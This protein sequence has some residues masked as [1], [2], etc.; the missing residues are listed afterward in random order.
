V[1]P[2]RRALGA[3]SN[4]GV[5]SE[6]VRGLRVIN[7]VSGLRGFVGRGGLGRRRVPAFILLCA[8]LGS[9]LTL[10]PETLGAPVPDAAAQ[11]VNP[12]VCSGDRVSGVIAHYEH[13]YV[14]V[15]IPNSA[16]VTV[17]GFV[18]VVSQDSTGY[19]QSVFHVNPGTLWLAGNLSAPGV[20]PETTS[21]TNTGSSR[22]VTLDFYQEVGLNVPFSFKVTTSSFG[23]PPCAPHGADVKGRLGGMNPAEAHGGCSCDQQVADPVDVLTGN[24]FRSFSDLDIGGRGPGIHVQRTYNSA[25]AAHNGPFGYGWSWSYGSSLSFGTGAATGR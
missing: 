5:S 24:F 20:Y 22:D 7:R 17:A 11:T 4:V 18:A 1:F 15:W 21:W 13:Y 14:D 23:G 6:D 9:V 12:R 16:S 2:A 10:V 3:A 19:W 25:A 8:L